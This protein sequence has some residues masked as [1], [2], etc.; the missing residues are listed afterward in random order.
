MATNVHPDE[1][2]LCKKD[3]AEGRIISSTRTTMRFV[4][5]FAF[6]WN[7]MSA[8][9][10]SGIRNEILGKGNRWALLLLLFPAVGLLLILAAIICVLRWRKFGESVF[11]MAS[12][13]GVIGGK[14]AGVIRTSAK[15]QP[16]DG[17]HLTLNCVQS[18]TH[19]DSSETT[20]WQD[21]QIIARDL[22]QS[23]S[24]RS[25]I[26]VLF[27]IPYDCRP[28]DE[29]NAYNKT[30]WQLN[31]SAKTPGVNYSTSF[32]VPVFKTPES[33]PNFVVDRS[34]IAEYAA[35][36]DPDRDLHDAGVVKMASPTGEGC[37]LVF[38][39]ARS[40]VM[41][42]IFA[43]AGLAFG[44]VPFFVYYTASGEFW[45]ATVACTVL[46]GGFGLLLLAV[47][48]DV[49]FYRSVV[50]VSAHGLVVT[51]GW[52]GL[53]RQRRIEAS[54]IEKIV[55]FSRM[56]AGEGEGKKMYYDI[57]I[58]CTTGKKVTAGKRVP[59]KRLAESVIRQIEHEQALGKQ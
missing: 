23:D 6:V 46:F 43:L 5:V 34:L 47:S 49:W 10:W 22:L 52:F 51:G 55:P 37:R 38:P 27:Q 4:S 2:W 24:A 12:V 18:V 48:A 11:E 3:W 20:L 36:A 45:F 8:L 29:T 17:F 14:L 56:G 53:G 31:V 21:E 59:G 15:V 7:L 32:D 54:D 41:A 26:P 57:D 16:E 30:I 44:G 28:T 35:P 39:M 50:D 58:V 42:A 1:P 33:D 9:M 25:A 40:P 19:S 13:P